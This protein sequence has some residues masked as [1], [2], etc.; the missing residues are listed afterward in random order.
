MD[1]TRFNVTGKLSSR[2]SLLF[3]SLKLEHL[4]AEGYVYL[5]FEGPATEEEAILK[6]T[7]KYIISLLNVCKQTD[8]Q[9]KIF[10]SIQTH[11]KPLECASI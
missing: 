10:V 8:L 9:G 2:Q 7:E 1:G 4:S 6:A 5:G 11:F 3:R